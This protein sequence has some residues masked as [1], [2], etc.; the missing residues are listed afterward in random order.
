M[1]TP[2]REPQEN[3]GN[4][5][6][7]VIIFHYNPAIFLGSPFKVP[8]RVPLLRLSLGLSLD[9]RPLTHCDSLISTPI[10]G[11]ERVSP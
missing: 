4:I 9:L 3:S 6:S 2:N 7:R 1:G 10:I 5:P 11:T 8:I